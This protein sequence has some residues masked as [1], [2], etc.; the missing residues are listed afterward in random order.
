MHVTICSVPTETPGAKRRRK[1]SDGQAGIMPKIAITSLNNWATRNGF[2]QCE[3]YDIDM[4]YP[5]DLEVEKYF[6]KNPTDIVG[7]SAVV[8]TSYLQVKRL[9]SI[10]KKVNKKTL[11][12]CG[13]YLTAA[14][15]TILKKTEVDICVV[16]NG[17]IAWVGI[18]NFVKEHL[19]TGKN[20]YD[21]DKLLEVKGI[22]ILD[23]SKK[24]KF[25]GYGKTLPG[26]EMTF[27]DFEYLKSGLQGDDGAFKNYFRHFSAN[28]IF[29]GD[30]RSYEKN[31][32]PMMVSM[33]T[34]KGCVAKCTFCQ[35]GSKGYSVYD[36]SKLES[37]LKHLRNEYDV[38]F[39]YVDDENFGSNRKYTWEVAELFNKY[40]MLWSAMGVRCSTINEEDIIHYKKNGCCALR[41][42][43]ESGS[44]TMLDIMEK[45][46]QVEDIKKAIFAC[47]DN[48]LYSPP[49][50]YMLGMPGESIKTAME[51][52]VMMGEISAKIGVPPS[53]IFGQIDP[54]YA[55]PLV[56]TP[57][58]EYGRQLGL[59]GQNIDE[60]EKYLELVSN[61]GAYKR[62]YI[63]FNGAP[64]S[65][66]VFWDMLVFLE[67]TRK[68]EKL[69]KNKSVNKKW[70]KKFQ[71][72]MEVQGL[73]PHVRAKQKKVAVMGDAGV[74]E[75]LSFSQ[76]FITNFLKQH[77]I[78]NKTLAKLPRFLLYPIV[79]YSLYAEYLMQK[80]WFK[81]SHNLHKNI[82]KK[83]N[84][85]IRIKR[86]DI[87]PAK[88]TQNE[89]SLR[90][91]VKKKVAQLNIST[92]E[93]TL[94]MLTGG[95]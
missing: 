87:D 19:N 76:Y 12:V 94:G 21:Y 75:E 90:T 50:G 34:S 22:A 29:A 67:A 84:S 92:D 40:N 16:G 53:L 25:S 31:R 77:V 80:Y 39:I 74:K 56:G 71:Q 78:F 32:K 95:P 43:I 72:V 52:G 26:C 4:L 82:N 17:E 60:E 47:Y 93:K 83:I 20:K 13:G 48:D 23:D 15:N 55:I 62:Y 69:M 24:L 6:R 3:F 30:K 18:L 63:N 28:E 66:V 68:Y 54:N 73:N 10:I 33:F 7:L 51:S 27:P 61:V 37:Y 64:M 35:R 44:Q 1:Q 81:D 42:G 2:S 9:T 5:D 88:T 89:R 91:I 79:R 57:L 45:K 65:E 8:S 46:F 49:I 86:D 36:L 59:I 85:K 14:A 58:Y 38:G 41:F 70:I 11:V